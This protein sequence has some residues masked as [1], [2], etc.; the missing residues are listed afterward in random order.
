MKHRNKTNVN[1]DVK[2][3][4]LLHL[5]RYLKDVSRK[6]LQMMFNKT[7]RE[8]FKDVLNIDQCMIACHNPEKV[9]KLIM[10][11]S[12]KECEG[13]ENSANYHAEEA[14]IRII[15]KVTHITRRT[16]EIMCKENITSRTIDITNNKL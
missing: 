15:D 12:L 14:E 7:Y 10:P 3:I 13:A 1:R 5:T 16:K 2:G 11:I 9:R 4:V 6:R 8:K